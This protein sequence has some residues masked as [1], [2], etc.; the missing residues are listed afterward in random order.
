MQQTTDGANMTRR[1]AI[2]TD[3]ERE[4]IREEGTDDKH[5]V[6]VSRVRRKIAEEL[7]ADMAILRE[8]HPD[9]YDEL[10]AVVCEGD[11]PR[12]T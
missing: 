12:D 5:Y 4:L 6:A 9:L 10:R 8:H 3:N 1:R 7:P 2:L 11:D